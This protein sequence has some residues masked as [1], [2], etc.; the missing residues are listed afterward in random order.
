MR[1]AFATTPSLTSF[2]DPT[3]PFRGRVI[4][5]VVCEVSAESYFLPA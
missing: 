5:Y 4:F 3:L 2:V 1:V